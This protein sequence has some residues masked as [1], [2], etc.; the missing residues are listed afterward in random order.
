[1]IHICSK[2]LTQTHARQDDVLFVPHELS[3]QLNNTP[4]YF[5]TAITEFLS[6]IYKDLYIILC[7]SNERVWDFDIFSF[8][9]H[10]NNN[11]M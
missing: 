7:I 11:I 10:F 3:L 1:M 8:K 6:E 9:I 2:R 4:A 5:N